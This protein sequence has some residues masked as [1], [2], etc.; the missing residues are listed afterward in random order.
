MFLLEAVQHENGVFEFRY[1]DHSE[2]SRSFTD[3]YFTNANADA[4]H[5]LPIA[6]FAALLNLIQLV[7]SLSPVILWKRAQVTEEAAAK[8]NGLMVLFHKPDNT[9][10]C[11]SEQAPSVYHA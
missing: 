11:I 9:K 2:S 1:I 4:C 3:A 6:R 5:W 7:A 8:L 10:F